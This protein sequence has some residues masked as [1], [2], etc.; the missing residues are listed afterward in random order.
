MYSLVYISYIPI[1]VF[2]LANREGLRQHYI[3]T[4]KNLL[5]NLTQ[6]ATIIFLSIHTLMFDVEYTW[7]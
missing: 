7:I 4:H 2:T 6:H 5:T 3:H 1:Q